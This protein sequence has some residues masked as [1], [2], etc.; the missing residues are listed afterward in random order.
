VSFVVL[1]NTSASG[2]AKSG[3][4]SKHLFC[5]Y[6]T[7]QFTPECSP[8]HDDVE[9]RS[10]AEKNYELSVGAANHITSIAVLYM[11]KYPIKRC[12]V[13]LCYYIFTASVMHVTSL[14][15]YSSDPQ[16]RMGLTKCM[17]VLSAMEIVWPS[18]A[19]ALELLRGSKVNIGSADLT[20]FTAQSVRQKRSA[21]QFLKDMEPQQL[22]GPGDYGA[23]VNLRPRNYPSN[24]VY[25]L[26]GI[27]LQP[28]SQP[29]AVPY[30][31][32]FERWPTDNGN[33]GVPFP[34]TLSTSVLPQIYST[35]LFDERGNRASANIDP[36]GSQNRYPQYWNDYSTYSQLGNH[37]GFHEQPPPVHAH[38][39]T[40]QLFPSEQYNI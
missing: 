27:P 24:F 8:D 38:S 3:T 5:T 23:P 11:E 9:A 37:N 12:P 13:F 29:P 31:P 40:S 39:S 20:A 16:A 34:N 32:L 30:L 7:I 36:N 21:E 18:A 33:N 25:S 15:T 28:S 17:E 6:L 14:S 10:I 19:R 2:C 1:I 26:E 22:Q 4:N 35:G